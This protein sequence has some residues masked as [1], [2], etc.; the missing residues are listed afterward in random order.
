MDTRALKKLAPSLLAILAIIAFLPALTIP[1]HAQG[2]TLAVNPQSNAGDADSFF[3]IF[4]EVSEVPALYAYDV[5]VQW[6]PAVLEGTAVD[7]DTTV[8]FAGMNHIPVNQETVPAGQVRSA[9][10]LIGVNSMDASLPT[11][12]LKITMRV[13]TAADTPLDLINTE[14]V[15]LTLSG[16]ELLAHSVVDGVFF[17]PPVI[18]ITG[19]LEGQNAT[20]APGQRQRFLSIGEHDVSLLGFIQLDPMAPRAGFGGIRFTIVAPD[21]SSSTVDSDIAFMFPGD[22]ATVHGTYMFGDLTGTYRLF[23]TALR[24]PTPESCVDGQTVGGKFFKVHF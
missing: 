11:A 7:F 23:A 10:T 12:L 17:A 19:G 8:G 22:F 18:L 1:A 9:A 6:D 15:A 20:V 4:V 14:L 24:C 21:G 3:D 16:V 13:L 5:T 2:P